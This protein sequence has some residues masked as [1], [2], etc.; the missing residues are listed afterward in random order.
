MDEMHLARIL[1]NRT[2]KYGD[3]EA[4]RYKENNEYKSI[5]WNVFSHRV[6]AVAK[7]L[8][9]EGFNQYD[10]IGIISQ[11]C[12]EWTIS[13]FA[14]LSIRAVSV[15]VYVTASMSQ[16][17]YIATETE[18]KAI[19]VGDEQQLQNILKLPVAAGGLRKIITFNCAPNPDPR[20]ISI[21]TIYEK[22]FDGEIDSQLEKLINEA[23]ANDL[24]TIIYTSGTTGEP[25][26]AM[27]SHNNY[28][29]LFRIHKQRLTFG[30]T[31]VSMCFLPLSHVF[32]RG[33]TYF[34][35]F[36]GAVNV[37]NANPKA[38]MEEM[39]KVK[40][41]VMCTV[42]RLFEKTYQ[43]IYE[44]RNHW[45]KAQKAIF[46]WALSVGLKYIQFE[47]N[48]QVAPLGLRIKRAIANALV[49]KKVQKVLGGNIRFMPCAGAAINPEILKFFHAFGIFIN[50]GY[51][52]TET[53]AT[54]SCFREDQY[55]FDLSCSIMPEVQVKIEGDE[56]MILVKGPTV[57]MGYYKKPEQTAEV[58]KD[59][60]Y[61][62]GD[63]G[64]MPAPGKL[65]MKERL[66]DLFKT[67]TGK[68]VSPQKIELM[69]SHCE[70]IEQI[71]VIGDDRRFISALIVPSFNKLKKLAEQN[72]IAYTDHQ[73]LVQLQLV[74]DA[75]KESLDSLQTELAPYERIAKFELLT[76]PFSIDNLLL[77]NTLKVKRKQIIAHYADLIES[78]Y[79]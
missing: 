10:N 39:P 24:A 65:I 69:V 47:K 68:M 64:E 20:V 18:M 23:S 5:S 59:G 53:S 33:W 7:Y 44:T 2:A 37:Y 57:F 62:T 71:C 77:T 50:Y 15:P 51:G 32:E 36:C 66:K 58:L 29:T 8:L 75:I 78:M 21:Q 73:S 13:D 45:P 17:E 25:K 60:W 28:I 27:L 42:P 48:S 38:I 79:N 54:V 40:P 19:F 74:K 63:M 72:N 11:N 3:R 46:D 30:D 12:P 14:I 22:I 55:D 43:V 34:V 56:H 26:G 49:F 9:A 4:L 16:L 41:T 35:I 31:D 6:D 76:E 67:S 52:A 61:Y 70:W 1:R